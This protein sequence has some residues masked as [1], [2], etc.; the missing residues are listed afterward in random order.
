MD[1]KSWIILETD[2]KGAGT[3]DSYRLVR[4][5]GSL[6]LSVELAKFTTYVVAWR[7]RVASPGLPPT[8]SYFYLQ[9]ALTSEMSLS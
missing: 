7:I 2:A 1:E 5:H 8:T 3:R 4:S 6:V 9:D